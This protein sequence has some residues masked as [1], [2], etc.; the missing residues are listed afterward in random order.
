M[1]IF[2]PAKSRMFLF[3]ILLLVACIVHA[4]EEIPD[5]LLFPDYGKE[6]LQ[7]LKHTSLDTLGRKPRIGLVLSGGGA[8][9][10]THIGVL[11]VLEEAGIKVDYITGTSMGSIMGCLYSVGYSADQIEEMVAHQD[12]DTLLMD[13]IPRHQIA[14]EEK[15]DVDKYPLSF[16]IRGLDISLPSGLLAGQN[17]YAYLSQ[18]TMS[19]HHINDFNKLPIPFRCIAT[20]IET[21]EAVV[22][23][24]G[25]L[26][27][28]IRAS[29]SIPSMFIPFEIEGRLLVDGGLVRN[30]PVVDALD[31]GADII[32]GV[33]VAGTPS[34]RDKLDSIISILS[35]AISFSGYRSTAE[36]KRLVDIYISPETGNYS[37]MDFDAADTLIAS[38]Y[39]A[40]MDR[41]DE[42][43]ALSDYMEMY[44]QIDL[45][46]PKTMIDS[47]YI[48]D[49]GIEGLKNVSR[50]LV[51]SKLTIPQQGWVRP[52]EIQQ[53]IERLYGS[54]YFDLAMYR[55]VPVAGGVKLIVKVKEKSSNLFKVGL[56]YDSVSKS[57]LLFNGTFRNLLLEGSKFSANVKLGD[58]YGWDL[59]YYLLTG[60]HPG[61]GF[62]AKYF[63]SKMD[64][65]AYNKDNERESYW[66]YYQGGISLMAETLV[67]NF[68]SIGAGAELLASEVKLKATTMEVDGKRI[69]TVMVDYF[70]KL[71]TDTLEKLNYPRKGGNLY[72]E[73][74]SFTGVMEAEITTGQKAEVNE[75]FERYFFRYFRAI[76]LWERTALQFR[77]YYGFIRST[78]YQYPE[79]QFFLG[80]LKYNNDPRFVPLIGLGEMKRYGKNVMSMMSAFQYEVLDD[81]YA[82][83]T[84]GLGKATDDYDDLWYKKHYVWGYGFTLGADTPI[85]PVEYTWMTGNVDKNG[86]SYVNIGYR[87]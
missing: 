33:N 79:F 10:L 42:L 8:L 51:Y 5:S 35:Q 63:E 11:K 77:G 45:P 87:F 47:V 50:D 57:A 40:A 67:D 60:R 27:D 85:G 41:F 18:L 66:D 49:I 23:D 7:H 1:R 38:G 69:S 58:Q 62:E 37:I 26:P 4:I 32:I 65:W 9:G 28:A 39:R 19:I 74:R 34:K 76:P 70:L 22:L 36:Q 59:R 16:A 6:I 12:W 20:D 72:A 48:L 54:Q 68:L 82:T 78:E 80:G 55:L 71:E 2:P 30:F 86:T 3:F 84:A 81:V 25:Y 17:F 53:G 61:V 31:M 73:F 52:E 44:P 15:L 29:M 24:H 83:V 13:K 64:I 14:L 46:E 21:G 56:H 75:D 43:T